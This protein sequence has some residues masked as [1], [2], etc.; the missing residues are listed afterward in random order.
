MIY[1]VDD[2]VRHKVV[3]L[4]GL[5]GP[6]NSDKPAKHSSSTI[7]HLHL[8]LHSNTQTHFIGRAAR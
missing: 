2:D 6:A 7:A 1:V 5:A 4:S 8:H 3:D